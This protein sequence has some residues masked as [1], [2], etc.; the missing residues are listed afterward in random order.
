MRQKSASVQTLVRPLCVTIAITLIC[1]FIILSPLSTP[2]AIGLISIFICVAFASLL[3]TKS[4][5]GE[6]ETNKQSLMSD[7]VFI[8][9]TWILKR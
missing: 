4:R 9:E 8:N 7:P 2:L 6:T 3:G 5:R 1:C